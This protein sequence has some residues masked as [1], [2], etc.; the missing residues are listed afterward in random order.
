VR[1]TGHLERRTTSAAPGG[2]LEEVFRLLERPFYL[3]VRSPEQVSVEEK[4][5]YFSAYIWA[6]FE[7]A[8]GNKFGLW[9]HANIA[10]HD[11]FQ[12]GVVRLARKAQ[13]FC[14]PG[15][16]LVACLTPEAAASLGGGRQ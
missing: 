11:L 6:L 15:D 12:D 9:E 5:V 16:R 10:D 1:L 14:G 7:T 13:E 4:S 8:K 3:V 2:K